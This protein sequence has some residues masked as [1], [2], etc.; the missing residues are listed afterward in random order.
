[1]NI[2]GVSFAPAYPVAP[3]ANVKPQPAPAGASTPPAAAA[4]AAPPAQGSDGDHD[5][6]GINVKA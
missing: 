5:G 6:S 3:Q 2:S 4:P 1:M